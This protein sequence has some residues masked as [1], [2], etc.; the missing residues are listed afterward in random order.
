MT[1]SR[2][3]GVDRIE[4]E[5]VSGW[6]IRGHSLRLAGAAVGVFRYIGQMDGMLGAGGPPRLEGL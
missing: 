6:T 3:L 2:A 1:K 5:S 4:L